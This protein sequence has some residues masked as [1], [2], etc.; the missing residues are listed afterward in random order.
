MSPRRKPVLPD[1][2]SPLPRWLA[3]LGDRQPDLRFRGSDT[4]GA[5]VYLVE[6]EGAPFYAGMSTR[7]LTRPLGGRHHALTEIQPTDIFYI[8]QF[9]EARE[10]FTFEAHLIARLAP[11]RN[12]DAIRP[13]SRP[14]PWDELGC[15]LR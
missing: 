1:Y 3:E 12:R 2:P 15:G 8:W 6:R 13:G 5:I 9:A 10:A 11:E 14:S 4:L 7:G